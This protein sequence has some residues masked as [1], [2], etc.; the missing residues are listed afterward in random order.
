MG[1]EGSLTGATS[2]AL[3]GTAV[4]FSVC[5]AELLKNPQSEETVQGEEKHLILQT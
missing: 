5:E 2:G 3:P 4:D 1:L